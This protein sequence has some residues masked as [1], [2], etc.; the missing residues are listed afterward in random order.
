MDYSAARV[1]ISVNERNAIVG[2]SCG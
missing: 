1:N 2:I